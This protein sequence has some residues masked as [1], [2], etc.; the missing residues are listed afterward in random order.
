[1]RSS[2]MSLS[3]GLAVVGS[4]KLGHASK[5]AGLLRYNALQQWPCMPAAETRLVSLAGQVCVLYQT[6]GH[7]RDACLSKTI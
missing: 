4:C 3:S 1:M 2:I 6:T 5:V 7:C